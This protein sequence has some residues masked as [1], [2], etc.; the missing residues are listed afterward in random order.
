MLSQYLR[1][2][3]SVVTV[4]GRNL[5]G[6]LHAAD[7]LLNIVLTSC[8]ERTGAPYDFNDGV[9][10]ENNG[11]VDEGTSTAGSSG[12]TARGALPPMEEVQLG[13]MMVRGSDVVT[14]AAIDVYE[15]AGTNIKDWR[16]RDMPPA[17]A[18]V[19]QR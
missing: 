5:V 3:V 18:A 17:A 15:E 13:V 7:Q 8:V 6:V 19:R 10:G 4:D 2:R 9:P 1:K 12:N 16:G 14:I 11:V